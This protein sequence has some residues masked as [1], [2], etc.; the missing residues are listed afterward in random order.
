MLKELKKV[1][2]EFG[3]ASSA[4]GI[5]NFFRSKRLYQKILWIVFILSSTFISYFLVRDSILDYLEYKVVTIT[6][7]VYEQPSEFPTITLRGYSDEYFK[8]KT[9]REIIKECYFGYNLD[10]NQNP[11]NYFDYY[12]VDYLGYYFRFNNG[13]NFS[14]HSIPILNSTIGGID[15]SLSIRIDK[16]QDMAIWIH[17]RTQPPSFIYENSHYKGRIF[18]SSNS[19]TEVTIERVV[20]IKLGEPYNDCLDDVSK[21]KY[22]KTIINY[23]RKSK[24]TYSQQKCLE[25]CFDI[26]YIETNRCNCTNSTVGNVWQNCWINLENKTKNTCTW[27]HKIDFYSKSIVEKCASYCPL[28]CTSISFN[29]QTSTMSNYNSTRVRIY[30][31]SLKYTLI[32]QEAKMHF[33]DMISNIGG[34]F[35]LLIGFS[36]IT[37]FEIFELLV[38]ITI[39]ILNKS[40]I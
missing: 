33:I 34:T 30:Y 14:N 20:E 10:C 16:N 17:N 5:P 36:F 8:N 3:I 39:R 4:Y 12:S 21:F 19:Y 6:Q 37:F 28:E 38:E 18:I 1:F 15:D 27:K 32:L 25:L 13:K 22:N 31:G 35:G 23:I 40:S 24:Q 2:K 7:S 9:P 26:D 11:N 29:I